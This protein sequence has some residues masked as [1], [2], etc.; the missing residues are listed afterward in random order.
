MEKVVSAAAV[1]LEPVGT[2]YTEGALAR[3]EELRKMRGAIPRFAIPPTPD[4]TSRLTSAASVPP[5][6][7][8]LAAVMTVANPEA[9]TRA[10]AGGAA[11]MRDL[12]S[13]AVAYTPLLEELEALTKFVRY[14][15]VAA[16]NQAGSEALGIYAHAKRLAKRP[17]YAALAPHVAGMR[18]VLGK[19][20]SAEV[21]AAR[22]AAKNAA[23]QAAAQV[24]ADVNVA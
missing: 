17:E 19:V 2:S 21:R 24:V 18:R 16:R 23:A 3:L 8:E 10:Q 22:K 4:A 6:F 14:S 13:Y 20:P 9:L 15:V 7:I 12:M 1:E 11:E 5:D